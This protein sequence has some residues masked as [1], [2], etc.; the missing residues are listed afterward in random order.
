MVVKI[1]FKKSQISAIILHN[2]KIYYIATISMTVWFRVMTGTW[3]RIRDRTL[4]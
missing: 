2:A 3:N 4:K 1:T